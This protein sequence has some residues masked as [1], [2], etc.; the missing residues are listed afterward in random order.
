M[1]TSLT[2]MFL[3]CV[4]HLV[5][6]FVQSGPGRGRTS[7]Q[8]GIPCFHFTAPNTKRSLMEKIHCNLRV[9]YTYYSLSKHLVVSQNK[10]KEADGF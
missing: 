1:L 6:P 9:K 4:P 3:I 2:C 8:R 7:A 10:R 5:R